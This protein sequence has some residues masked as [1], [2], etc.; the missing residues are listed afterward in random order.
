MTARPSTAVWWCRPTCSTTA[1]CEPG[2]TPGPH[3]VILPA[4]GLGRAATVGAGSLVMR[5]ETVPAGTA[6]EGNPI[7]PAAPARSEPRPAAG[8]AHR[9][10][11]AYAHGPLA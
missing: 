4:A 2:A 10:V 3:S 7:A 1:S 11:Y 8:Q 6:W 5:G 9:R